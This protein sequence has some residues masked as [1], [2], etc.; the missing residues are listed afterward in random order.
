[1]YC[2]N[3]GAKNSVEQKFCRSCGMNLESTVVSFREQY[4]DENNA[5]IGKT[6]RIFNALGKFGFAGFVTLAVL[7]FIWLIYTIIT[8]MVI[9]GSDPGFG[10]FFAGFLTFAAICLTWVIFNEIKKDKEKE[11]P[12]NADLINELNTAQA[13]DTGKLLADPIFTPIPSVTEDTTGLLPVENETTRI[14]QR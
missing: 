8:K 7:G 13:V 11:K 5:L 9:G 4:G 14:D 10:I 12:R 2:P 1:M 3:C 6:D